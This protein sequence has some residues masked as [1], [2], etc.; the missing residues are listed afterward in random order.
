[1][2]IKQHIK[3][4]PKLLYKPAR[5]LYDRIPVK[6][7]LSK[8]YKEVYN[9]TYKFLE[10]SQWWSKSEH[11]NYQLQQII[12]L[13]NH[14]YHTVPYYHTLLNEHGI[15]ISQIQDFDDFK[16]IPYLTKEIIQNNIESL[17]SSKYKRSKL[18]IVTTGGSTGVPLGFYVDKDYEIARENAF[19]DFLYT[20][21]NYKNSEKTFVLRGRVVEGTNKKKNTYFQRRKINNELLA[22]SYHLNNEN[23]KYYVEELNKYNPVCIKAYPSSL[24]LISNYVINNNIKIETDVKSII[25]ASENIYP[26]QREIYKKVFPNAKIFSFYGHSEH[27]CLAGECEV[28][29]FYHLQSEYGFTELINETGLPVSKEDELGEIVAT[30]YNNFAMP[31]IRYK[32]SDIAINTNNSCSCGR[33]YKLIKGIHGREQEQ[34]ISSDGTKIALTSIIHAQ[35][36]DSLGR[37]KEYQLVQNERGKVQIRIVPNENFGKN[38]INQIITKMETAANKKL[39]VSIE[40][41]DFIPK[42]QRGK[43]KFLIQ[44]IRDE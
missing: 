39:K 6:Y 12:K 35:H 25:L 26:F 9:E 10:K 20:R 17:V 5:I 31:F 16:K 33:N 7:K 28:S 37:I 22:S 2:N 21:I 34:I 32:T 18:N 24:S 36:L 13:V 4:G 23:I 30:S 38:D 1:M 3:N 11:Q 27:A 14:A 19:I 43:H 44:N 42:T 8:R 41:V 29:E 40:L 15:K